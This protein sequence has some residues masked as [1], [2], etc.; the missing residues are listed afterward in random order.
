MKSLMVATAFTVCLAPLASCQPAPEPNPFPLSA[1]AEFETMC[2]F[3]REKCA[4]A[5]DAI[6]RTMTYPEYKTALTDFEARGVMDTRIV[7]ASTDCG[8]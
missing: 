8:R 4:C 7:R 1:R 5:W 6:T 3:G 2:R